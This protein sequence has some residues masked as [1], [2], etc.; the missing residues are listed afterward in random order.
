MRY[1]F[2]S[3]PRICKRCG[4]IFY[5]V[6]KHQKYCLRCIYIRNKKLYAF[7]MEKL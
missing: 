7:L 4:K 3:L 2:V 1:R 5:K 6:L